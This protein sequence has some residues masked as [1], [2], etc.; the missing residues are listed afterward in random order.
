M[1]EIRVEQRIAASPSTVYRYLTESEKWI[2]WQ[3]ENADLDPRP[4]GHFLL[5]MENG[6]RARGQF[7][8]LVPDARVVFT[9]GWV[10]RPGIPPGSTEVTVELIEE[11]GG[12]L[13]ILT[14]RALPDDEVTAHREGWLLHLPRLAEVASTG[15]G[16]SS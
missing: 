13:L 6:M 12:T 15:R 1:S 5:E 4:G 3:S 16:R 2:L 9:W 14:H 11:D 7:V 8:E 10:D